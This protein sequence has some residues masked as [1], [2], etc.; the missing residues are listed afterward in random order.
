MDMKDMM[1][2]AKKELIKDKSIVP[3]GFAINKNG[4][5]MMFVLAFENDEEKV[6]IRNMLKVVIK[7]SGAK[8]YYM[9][10]EV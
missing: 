8:E 3:K 10:Q 5:I 1:E 9:V 4:D 2:N 6:K 7:K